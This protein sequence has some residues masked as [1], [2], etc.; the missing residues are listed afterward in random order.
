MTDLFYRKL[1]PDK[2]E[3]LDKFQNHLLETSQEIGA[4]KVWQFQE[5]SHQ[6]AER[7][8]NSP[9]EEALS[10]LID[11]SQNFP[12]QVM[13]FKVCA[14]LLLLVKNVILYYDLTYISGKIVNQNKS[15]QRYEERD[16]TKS[17]HF[18]C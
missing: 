8:M 15:E 13:I 6:A 2:T 7:I 14:S 1:Y 16:E 4:L 12:I 11:I 10:V 18:C 17:R 5:L 3:E 9:P